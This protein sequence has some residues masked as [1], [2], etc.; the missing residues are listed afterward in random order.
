VKLDL[1]A[2]HQKYIKADGTEATGVTTI[3]GVLAKPPIVYWTGEEERNGILRVMSEGGAWTVDELRSVLPW[4]K[5]TGKAV[6]FADTKRDRAADLGTVTH[7]RCEA[8]NKGEELEPD[9]IPAD[10]YAQSLHGFKRYK[11]W[12]HESGLTVV[13]VEE[14]FV[15]ESDDDTIAYG[16]TRDVVC[17]DPQRRRVLVDLKTSKASRYW[18]YDETFAQVAAYAHPPEAE[19]DRIAVVRIGKE[20]GDPGRERWLNEG[21]RG[22]GWRIFCGAYEAY[23][24]KKQLTSAKKQS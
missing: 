16:G 24:G 10:L 9:G 6:L 21:E 15:C 14:Q 4:N 11:T 12:L 7:A 20:P 17:V 2:P 8:F 5:A 22:A 18:P 1:S 3:L 23:E 13:A 19:I